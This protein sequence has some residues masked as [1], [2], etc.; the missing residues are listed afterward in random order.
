[1]KVEVEEIGALQA[2]PRRSR[3]RPTWSAG[4]GAA[5][6]RVQREARLPGSAR[7]RCRASMIKLHF[8]DDVKQEVARSLIPD[9]YRQA[10]DETKLKPVEEPD[11]QEVRL[12]EDAPL[13]FS[14]VVEIKPAI[15]LGDY[16]GL[17]VNHEPKPLTDD[18]VDEAITSS[19]SST[20]SSAP[21]SAPPTS[22]TS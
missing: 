13:A 18:E 7:A 6:N 9:V 11:L 5:F 22:A 1:M 16:A 4:L 21:S 14:A 12:E 15:A 2:A 19:A 3:R 8:A 20:R 17:A 10:L